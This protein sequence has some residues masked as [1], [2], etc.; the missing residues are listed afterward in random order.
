MVRED[1]SPASRIKRGET[2]NGYGLEIDYLLCLY[3]NVSRQPRS[4]GIGVDFLHLADD[5][6]VVQFNTS[7]I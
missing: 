2:Q 6:T 7:Q 3:A 4:F 5:C 1:G